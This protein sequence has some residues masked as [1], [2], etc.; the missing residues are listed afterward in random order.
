MDRRFTVGGWVVVNAMLPVTQP[1]QPYFATTHWSVILEAGRTE[2][3]QAR[4]ALEELCRTYW[5]PLYAHARRIG[6]DTHTA[7]D[8][9][10]GFFTRLLEKNYLSI[11]DRRRGK[12]RWF[13][14]TA[15]KC[16][17]ANEWDRTRALKRGGGQMPIPLDAFTAEE[18]LALETADTQSADLVF[19]RRWA[20]TLL[21]AARAKLQAEF[22]NRGK[23][24]RFEWL[25]GCLPGERREQ[26]YAEIGARLKMTE[27]AVKVEVGRM[28]RR[29][30][31]LLREVVGRTVVNPEE[32]EEELRHLISVLGHR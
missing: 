1:D 24:E 17:L 30:A 12:F 31:E 23:A 16:F 9:T 11:A 19:D 28:R 5:Y 3:P 7:E 6:H 21:D 29:Y 26:T 14:L 4:Q 18:Q 27:A 32:I 20:M 13:L 10:Q 25:E 2:S 22:A 15:F 8:L